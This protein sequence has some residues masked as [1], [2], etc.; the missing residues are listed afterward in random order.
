V[1]TPTENTFVGTRKTRRGFH[2]PMTAYIKIH[3][4]TDTHSLKTKQD[5]QTFQFHKKYVCSNRHDL[6]T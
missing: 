4:K 6:V 5:K 3:C 2:T 1:M